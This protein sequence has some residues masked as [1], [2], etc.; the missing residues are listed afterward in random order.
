MKTMM[1]YSIILLCFVMVLLVMLDIHSITLRKSEMEETASISMYN[2]LTGLGIH[3]MYEMDEAIMEAE[4]IREFANNINT[5]SG[6]TLN[7]YDL[8][9]EGLID[10]GII[11]D[12]IHLNGT[13][14]QRSLRKT[15]ILEE[16]SLP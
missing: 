7:V 6:Y 9:K 5:D 4:L 12:F 2:T 13:K 15:M 16:Y 1:K 3:K 8:S 11:M 10:V 14:D